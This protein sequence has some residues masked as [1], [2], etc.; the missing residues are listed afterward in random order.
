[1]NYWIMKSEPDVFSID[2]LKQRPNQTESWDGVRNYQARNMLRDLM[3]P[4]D[5]AFFYHSSCKIPGIVGVMNIVKGGYVDDSAFD[6][7]Q[8]YYDPNSTPDKPR[9]YKVDVKF[10]KKFKRTIALNELK[11]HALLQNMQL[12]KKGNRLS[13][14]PVTAIEWQTI[15]NMEN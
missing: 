6:P 15:Y 2:D 4:G 1:M 9:W 3:K 14:M 7:A 5:A 10:V 13:I 8:P 12:L 11:D